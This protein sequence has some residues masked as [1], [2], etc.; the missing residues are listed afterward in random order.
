MRFGSQEREREREKKKSFVK[1]L[2]IK[3]DESPCQQ[4]VDFFNLNRQKIAV[5][6]FNI[7]YYVE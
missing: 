6:Q 5:S 3:D 2:I 7:F 1:Q 4:L